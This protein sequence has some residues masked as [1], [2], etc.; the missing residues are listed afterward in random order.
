MNN[1]CKTQASIRWNFSLTVQSVLSP[2]KWYCNTLI[3]KAEV[4]EVIDELDAE[5]HKGGRR[6]GKYLLIPTLES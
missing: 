4:D 2:A 1:T 5:I 6:E 3:N